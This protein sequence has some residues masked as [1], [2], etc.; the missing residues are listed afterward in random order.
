MPPFRAA[1]RRERG[2]A[3]KLLDATVTREDPRGDNGSNPAKA[4]SHV[5]VAGSAIRLKPD[6]T[7]LSPHQQSGQSRIPRTC[8]RISHPAKA[9]SHVLAA[10]SAIRLNPHPTYLPPDCQERVLT[11]M[12]P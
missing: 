1:Q 3:C 7:Y 5:L 12:C 6:P 11:M 9:G 4:G 10:G 8:R 2:N